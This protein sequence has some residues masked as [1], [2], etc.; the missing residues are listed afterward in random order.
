MGMASQYW[1]R[2]RR[3]LP[4]AAVAIVALILILTSTFD[5][6]W[7]RVGLVLNVVALFGLAFWPRE[8]KTELPQRD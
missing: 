4:I 3:R 6:G 5:S 2:S 8:K 7:Y 1:E